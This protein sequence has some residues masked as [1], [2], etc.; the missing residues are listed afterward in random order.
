MIPLPNLPKLSIR[1]KAILSALLAVS[2]GILVAGWLALRSLEQLELARLE[3][4]LIVR[5]ELAAYSLT[6]TLSPGRPLPLGQRER[7]SLHRAT[8]EIARHALARV[9]VIAPDGTVLAD[10]TIPATA[11]ASQLENHRRRP[12]VIQALSDGRGRH[13]RKSATTGVNTAYFALRID[14]PSGVAVAVVRLGLPLTTLESRIGDLQHALALACSV[15]LGAAILLSL[16]IFNGLTKP[17]SD[18]AVVARRIA[19]GALGERVAG[20]SRDEVGMLAESIN[21]M[22]DQLESKIQ[23]VSEDRAQLLAMLSSMVEGVMVLDVQGRLLRMN[24]AAERMFGL[25]SGSCSGQHIDRVIRHQEFA[26]LVRRVL[27]S[28]EQGGGEIT[29]RP[30]GT[31]LRIEAT[32]TDCQRDD[33]ACAVF[34]LHDIT[35]LRRL[36]KVRKDFVA[37]VSHELRTPLTSIKGYVEALLDGALSNPAQA[38]PFLQII[39]RQADRLNLI[40]ED[41]LQLSQIES[42]QVHF[43]HEPVDLKDLIERSLAMIKPIADKKRHRVT[44]ALPPDLPPISGD[45]E[46]LG[47]VL[48]NLLDNAV[49]YTPE[50]GRIEIS[51]RRIG[52]SGSGQVELCVADSGVGIPPADRPRVFERFYRVDKARSR[53]LGGTGLGLSIVK[54]IVEGHRGAIWVEGN[55][56]F[57]SRFLIRLPIAMLSDAASQPLPQA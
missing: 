55:D 36:E 23:Q 47:Q 30:S 33:E 9:T 56:P 6:P 41:L 57:G 5:T 25:S 54:H 3:E 15:A 1:L 19:G 43:K 7:E 53:E 10:S 52:E 11:D 21:Q 32:V 24:P 31:T 42:G 2:L 27:A 34:V 28:K 26:E 45:E 40:I 51:G 35:A 16:M 22:A 46:R 49:K 14:G 8:A 38:E 13:V 50:G 17:L 44:L 48:T 4:T 39:S 29:M 18:I 37:N 20:P 12:E